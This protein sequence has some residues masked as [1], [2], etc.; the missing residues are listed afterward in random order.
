MKKYPKVPRHDL[1]FVPRELFTSSDLSLLE[2]LDGMNLRFTLYED[3]FEDEY[4]DQ[5]R[6]VDAED[7]DIVFGTKSVVRG[8]VNG[9]LEEFDGE[10]KPVVKRLR[11][12][13]KG[14][15][16]N[17]QD[18]YGPL[19]IYCEYMIPH[20]L[21][22]GYDENPPP[23]IIGFDV[24]SQRKDNRDP[25][26][27]PSNPYKE[28]FV[29]F[30][31]LH[32]AKNIIED[33][34]IKFAPIVL[35]PNKENKSFHPDK[36]EV[37]MSEYGN[38]RAE[39]VVIRSDELE[40]RSKYVRQSFREMHESSMGGHAQKQN[41]PHDWM[42]DALVS[43]QR[44]RKTVRKLV[45]QHGFK[46]SDSDEFVDMVTQVT[47]IDAWKE[48]FSEIQDID[49]DIRPSKIHEPSRE[50]V[51]NVIE[52]M[53][54]TSTRT[55]QNPID[56]WSSLDNEVEDTQ[57][58]SPSVIDKGIGRE[59][60]I[61]IRVYDSDKES[62]MILIDEIIGLD[63]IKSHIQNENKQLDGSDLKP[64]A[65]RY[66]ELFWTKE[67]STQVLW[68]LN[69]SFNPSKVRSMIMNIVKEEIEDKEGIDLDKGGESWNPSDEDRN[70]DGVNEFF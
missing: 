4:S 8:T 24:Y 49:D 53:K 50:R 35:D 51:R 25:S 70:L 42:V 39:G 56:V 46:F 6:E 12:V 68:R 10:L 2:K 38:V 58:T 16:R 65:E 9:D 36:F 41:N 40:I 59:K 30:L 45:N 21:D 37:P 62:E 23:E 43:P 60:E 55:D 63:E 20:T 17:F 18:E 44:V 61:A 22:Y 11:D 7:G 32:S 47:L 28:R 52:R 15:M 34:D 29:G 69:I 14:K 67:I 26:D 19:V 5:I 27:Y 66:E 1:E 13:R 3:R 33:L 48:E 31:D 64:I 54:M 57:A